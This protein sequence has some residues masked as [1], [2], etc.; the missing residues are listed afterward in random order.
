MLD[1]HLYQ[2]LHITFCERSIRVKAITRV[3]NNSFHLRV[4]KSPLHLFHI[5]TTL[6]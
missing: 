3:Q 1:N 4:G 5:T 6:V 2:F